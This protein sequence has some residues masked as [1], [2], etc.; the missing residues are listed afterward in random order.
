M[1]GV[2]HGF[3]AVL[4]FSNGLFIWDLLFNCFENQNLRQAFYDSQANPCTWFGLFY[5]QR[6]KEGTLMLFVGSGA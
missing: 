6:L 2:Y 3:A 5:L 4:F 1:G